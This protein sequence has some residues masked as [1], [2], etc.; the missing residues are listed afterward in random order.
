MAHEAKKSKN[1][2]FVLSLIIFFT[3][4]C[5]GISKAKLI[6]PLSQHL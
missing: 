4:L 2:S 1:F 3:Q 6:P 5:G